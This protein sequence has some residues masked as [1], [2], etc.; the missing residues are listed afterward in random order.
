MSYEEF[1]SIR[2]WPIEGPSY[3]FPGGTEE[4]QSR[5]LAFRLKFYHIMDM[6][7]KITY[8]NLAFNSKPTWL[9]TWKIKI[10][11][12]TSIKVNFTLRREQCP[13]TFQSPQAPNISES[14]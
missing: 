9:H 4:N 6:L 5:Q 8:Y 10:N 13:L 12:T 7:R 2:P 14:I 11:E 3:Y 1:G